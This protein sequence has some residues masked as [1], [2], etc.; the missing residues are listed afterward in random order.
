MGFVPTNSQLTAGIEHPFYEMEMLAFAAD[1]VL[2]NSPNLSRQIHFALVESFVTHARALL[3]F[4][5]DKQ[6]RYPTDLLATDFVADPKAWRARHRT[7]PAAL[8]AFKIRA[9]KEVAHVTTAR[10]VG[11]PPSKVWPVTD[12][13]AALTP[14]MQEF[15]R[16]VEAT[17]SNAAPT[18]PGASGPAFP[19][20]VG[21]SHVFPH[22]MGATGAH[23]SYANVATIILKLK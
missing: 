1:A 7:P 23:E 10:V 19:G 22:V 5:Y 3:H 14:A 18:L 8:A 20:A 12:I 17:A 16:D 6:K 9:D 2:E 11:I 13:R 4:F 21:G 15:V